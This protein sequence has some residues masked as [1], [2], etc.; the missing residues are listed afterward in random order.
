MSLGRGGERGWMMMIAMAIE[1]IDR[2]VIQ[3]LRQERPQLTT[4][5]QGPRH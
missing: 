3:A 5:P 1:L 4:L 2:V